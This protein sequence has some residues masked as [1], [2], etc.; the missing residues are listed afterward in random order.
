MSGS[1]RERGTVKWFDDQKGY[2]FIKPETGG[3]VFVHQSVVAASNIDDLGEGDAVI[4]ERAPGKKGK[5]D[6]AINLQIV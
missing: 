3:D 1:E 6:K 4:F 2:G 5:G